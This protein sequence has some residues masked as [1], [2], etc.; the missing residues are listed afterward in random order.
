MIYGRGGNLWIFRQHSEIKHGRVAMA[1][2]LGAAFKVSSYFPDLSDFM[3]LLEPQQICL[4]K[5][6]GILS[7]RLLKGKYSPFLHS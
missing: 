2:F 5:S 7:L 4:L 6:S 1:A 3:E